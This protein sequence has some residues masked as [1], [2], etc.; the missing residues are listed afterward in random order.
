MGRVPRGDGPGWPRWNDGRIMCG[1]GET[2]R[3]VTD[4]IGTRVALWDG[5]E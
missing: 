3:A 5:I 4:P 2:V 1:F